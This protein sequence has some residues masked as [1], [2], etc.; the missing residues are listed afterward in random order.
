MV[1][2]KGESRI[3]AVLLAAGESTRMAEMKALLPWTSGQPLLAYQA[4][5]IDSAGYRPIVV[6]L[7]HMASRLREELCD[8]PNAEVVE[9]T[10]YQQGRSTSIV[11]GLRV[12]PHD[13]DGI[14]ILSVDQPRSTNLLMTLKEAWSESLPPV[15]VPSLQGRAGHPP[16]F[17]ADLRPELS[18]IVEERE[19]LREITARY[20]DQ[21]LLVPVDDPLT[22]TNLNTRDQYDAALQLASTWHGYL[23]TDG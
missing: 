20:R 7:G 19:G 18:S 1:N 4:D 22:L 12:L 10:R 21:R 6:V 3:A 5:A 16:L 2:H 11:E 15:A 23:S 8:Y 9:N 14:L 17:S 13:I